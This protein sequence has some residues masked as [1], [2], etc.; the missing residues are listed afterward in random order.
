MAAA[1]FLIEAVRG[2]P[3]RRPV[4]RKDA[5]VTDDEFLNKNVLN[6]YKALQY[7]IS[8]HLKLARASGIHVHL[9]DGDVRAAARRYF[10]ED[11]VGK[12]DL[13][14]CMERVS[15]GARNPPRHVFLLV[16][17][18]Y[19]GWPLMEKY[20]SLGIA[21]EMKRLSRSGL[22]LTRFLPASSGTMTSLAT[23]LTGLAEHGVPIC[24]QE[25][26]RKPFPSSMAP[27]F[28]RL[29]YRT[30]F[31]YAGYLSWQR[32]GDF[33]KDQGFEE[34]YGGGDIGEWYRGN[35]W[36]VTDEELLDFVLS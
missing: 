4:Q 7:T 21:E 16:L 8:V 32:I 1:A 19:S 5:A 3:G 12:G 36:G 33:V 2:S 29:G 10:G 28:K 9:P 22:L 34:V 20:A 27:I 23:I 17:E 31:F 11:A 30:R 13:D 18:G 35:E 15:R 6:P 24:Y 26:A 25:S 14:R